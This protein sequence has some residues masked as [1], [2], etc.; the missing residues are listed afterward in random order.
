[1]E[2]KNKMNIT[3]TQLVCTFLCINIIVVNVASAST[4]SQ[5]EPNR[6]DTLSQLLPSDTADELH[7]SYLQNGIPINVI[8]L[9]PTKSEI[10]DELELEVTSQKK[11]INT[12]K[13][14][15]HR[16]KIKEREIRRKEK[17]KKARQ[18]YINSIACNPNNITVITNLT[19]KDMKYATKGTWWEGHESTLY[20]LEQNHQINALFAMAVS[21]LES[22]RGTSHR[23]SSRKN[24]YGIELSTTWDNL[25][26]C[27][28]YWGGMM[29]RVYI[30]GKSV[31]SVQSIGPIYCPPNREWEVFVESYMN[32]LYAKV[33][34]TLN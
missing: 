10:N 24:Y 17:Q 11:R 14:E 33:K 7:S 8:E 1:M 18:K 25:Y 31:K 27:T 4:L 9:S 21:T 3:K 28:Q 12:I 6:L 15:I 20:E 19:Q 2:D 13:K 16:R 32:E 30:N 29:Q 5:K 23:A 22:G 34:T 26:D